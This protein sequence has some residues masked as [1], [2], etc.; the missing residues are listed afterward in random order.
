MNASALNLSSVNKV[1]K[2]LTWVYATNKKVNHSLDTMSSCHCI[3]YQ[4]K[5]MIHAREVYQN[6]P[7]RSIMGPICL[8]FGLEIFSAKF[9]SVTFLRLLPSNFVQKSEKKSY[10]WKHDN[11]CYGQKD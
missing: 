9:S 6:S 1:S 7:F 11:V 5:L 8:E 2:P 10:D 4:E 3:Q